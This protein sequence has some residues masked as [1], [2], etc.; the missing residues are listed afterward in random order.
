[1]MWENCVGVGIVA[2]KHRAQLRDC[3]KIEMVNVSKFPVV[4]H[5]G[6]NVSVL[7]WSMPPTPRNERT[8]PQRVAPMKRVEP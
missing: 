6:K 3:S 8:P 5:A 4:N 1:M 2:M 7:G